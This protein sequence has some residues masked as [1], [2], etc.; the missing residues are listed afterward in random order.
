MV[1]AFKNAAAIQQAVSFAA[2]NILR[3]GDAVTLLFIKVSNKLHP[4]G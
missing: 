2:N 3:S 4:S 1:V